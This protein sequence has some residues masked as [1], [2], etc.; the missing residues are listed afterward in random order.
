MLE[1]LI[2]LTLPDTL[3]LVGSKVYFNNLYPKEL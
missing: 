1:R 3:T 2:V